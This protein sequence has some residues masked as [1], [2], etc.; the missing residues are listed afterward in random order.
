MGCSSDFC[1]KSKSPHAK[2][3][4]K[5]I[6]EHLERKFK[7]SMLDEAGFRIHV[8]GCPHNC[9]A[10]LVAE[11]GLAG[12]ILRE[13]EKRKQAYD[14]LLGGSLGKDP[15][16]GKVIEKRVPAIEVKYRIESLLLNYY[17]LREPSEKLGEFCNK[18]KS[19]DLRT[20]LKNRGSMN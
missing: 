18:Q 10:N 19:N 15:R 3:I 6:L 14:I 11:I 13:G 4:T 5:D 20:Y 7:P 12:R 9:C 16:F 8:S 17:N 1:G 2:Q